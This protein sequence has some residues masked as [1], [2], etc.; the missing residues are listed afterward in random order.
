LHLSLFGAREKGASVSVAATCVSCKY[1]PGAD[2]AKPRLSAPIVVADPLG[3]LLT[4]YGLAA[5]TQRAT[6]ASD[7]ISVRAI[8]IACGC[9]RAP[10]ALPFPSQKLRKYA[11]L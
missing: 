8:A 7:A 9:L 11:I 6:S 1:A 5:A 2:K 4:W 10:A 3:H